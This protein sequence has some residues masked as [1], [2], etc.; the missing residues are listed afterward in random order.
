[1]SKIA[2]IFPGMGY[3]ADKPLLHYSRRLAAENGYDIRVIKFSGF[4]K[5]IAGDRKSMEE[6]F[7]IALKQSEEMLADTDLTAYEDILFIGK[8]IGT[9][10]AAKIASESPAKDRIRLIL[11]TPLEDTFAFSF[12]EA[13][14]FTGSGDPW[15]GAEKNRIP[16]IC[17]ERGIPCLISPDANHSLEVGDALGDIWEMARIMR[18][19]E[20][21][22]AGKYP[23]TGAES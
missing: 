3:T 20:L 11:Y 19:T 14:A 8:S 12:G 5:K 4:P 17:E 15:V 23:L 16:A 13:I 18:D 9:I 1:M 22:I 2:V 21:F 6:S 7:A 10:A